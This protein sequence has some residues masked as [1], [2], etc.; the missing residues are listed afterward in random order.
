MGYDGRVSTQTALKL[1]FELR[2]VLD[3][4]GESDITLHETMAQDVERAVRL[5]NACI[6]HLTEESPEESEAEEEDDE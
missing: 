5:T 3:R 6:N 2:A 4:I 1:L